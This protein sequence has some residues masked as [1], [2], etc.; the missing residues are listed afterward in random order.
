[1]TAPLFFL[2][3]ALQEPAAGLA[4]H[5]GS[6]DGAAEVELA[7]SGKF[8]VHGLALD[9][10]DLERSRT[11][12]RAAGLYPLASVEAWTGSTLPYADNLLNLFVANLDLLGGRSP[13]EAE[14]LR[15]LRPGGAARL[16]KGGE[17][18]RLLKARPED[19]DDWTHF[20]HGSDGNG[21]SRDRRVAPPHFVQ[22]TSGVQEIK[23]GGNPA[24]FVNLSGIRVA[25]GRA[26]F[27]YQSGKQAFLAARDAWN[28]VPLWTIPRPIAGAHRRWQLVAVG[29]RI[30]TF[31]DR[32]LV[33]L[34][35][36]SGEPLLHFEKAAAPVLP[37]EGTQ[38]RV[39][40]RT[41]L[42]NLE[43]GLHALDP[44]SGD[45]LWSYREADRVLAFPAL[46]EEAGFAF[47]A[48]VAPAQRLRSRWPSA[49]ADAVVCLDL[50]N[51]RVVWRN[52]DV[53]GKP[54]G[55]LIHGDGLLGL[56]AGSAIG[57]RQKEGGW[58]G[59][60]GVADG[61]L[62][63]QGTFV[64][65]YNDSMYNA[66]LRDGALWYAGH[67]S[68]YRFEPG[69]GR[70]TRM[71]N[72][73]YNQRCN[74]FTAT[75]ELWLLGYIT[76]LDK[77]LNGTLQTPARAGC[78]LG[79]TPANGMVY[80]TPSACNCFT[81]LRGYQALSPEPLRPPLEGREGASPPDASRQAASP[82]GPIPDDWTRGLARRETEEVEVDGLQLVSVIHEHRVEA[83]R[84]TSV[85]WSST[86]GGRVSGPPLVRDGK[87]FFGSHDGWVYAVSVADGARLWRSRVA[88]YERKTV[89]YGQLESSWPVYGV[90]WHDGRVVASA[91]THPELGGGVFVRAFDP[92]T[93]ATAW[94]RTLSKP[95]ATITTLDGKS[96]GKIVPQSFLN[97]APV[98]EAG[99][100]RVGAFSF[101]P[102]ESDQEIR[103]RLATPPLKKR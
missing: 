63:G 11:G 97:E 91:G 59:A 20:D 54:I 85:V 49:L 51:G 89:A 61:R 32:R 3:L 45:L 52:T 18:V 65:A 34:D 21:L 50:R 13:S 46:A 58:V 90:A 42:L 4:A 48:V 30:Y 36:A 75:P 17:W 103:E 83:R 7:R 84:G 102:G 55:Q 57:G 15:V 33:A 94:R 26:V 92:A 39:G 100:V 10:A 77:S 43:D 60:I 37:D 71:A 80:L 98:S 73:S 95:T 81:Q 56:F 38:L 62:Q 96:S 12:I 66:L 86:A 41:L 47:A 76:Y 82:A 19:I 72:L 1:M 78:A 93:G 28:G 6:T 40:A 68:L 44:R 24:G 64:S 29:G 101:D 23:L 5:A 9:A 25:D 53:A 87:A 79:S 70:I 74:R 31:L 22:W 14:I 69:P 35:A 8:L 16:R 67:T 88:P 2:L 99:R 27:D